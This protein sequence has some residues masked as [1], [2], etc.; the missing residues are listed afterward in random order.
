ML[1]PTVTHYFPW[2]ENDTYDTY[3]TYAYC[4]HRMTVADVHS[5]APTCRK[6]S[7]SRWE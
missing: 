1:T 2:D 7:R 6:A 4:G 5:P 3:D